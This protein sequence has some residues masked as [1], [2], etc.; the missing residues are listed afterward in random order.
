VR[1]GKEYNQKQK[2]LKAQLVADIWA[3]SASPYHGCWVD[4]CT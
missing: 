1:K 3:C 2:T 4:G